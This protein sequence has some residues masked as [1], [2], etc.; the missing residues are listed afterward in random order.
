MF[1]FVAVISPSKY[2]G[3]YLIKL[4]F[5]LKSQWVNESKT[6]PLILGI[7]QHKKVIGGKK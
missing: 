4:F 2:L 3:I 1:R 7:L 6:T 5:V